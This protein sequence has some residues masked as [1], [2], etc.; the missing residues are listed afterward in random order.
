MSRGLGDVYKRQ[1]LL[2]SRLS[3]ISHIR[4]IECLRNR[5][6]VILAVGVV[7]VR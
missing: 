4:F 5:N 6:P 3:D 1:A 7:G 2:V